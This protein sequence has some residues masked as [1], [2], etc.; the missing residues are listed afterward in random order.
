MR[1]HHFEPM[2]DSCNPI[3]SLLRP[4]PVEMAAP[5]SYCLCE[6]GKVSA[7]HGWRTALEELIRVPNAVEGR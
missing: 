4:K 7:Q 2:T 6:G 3:E 5:L 1:A